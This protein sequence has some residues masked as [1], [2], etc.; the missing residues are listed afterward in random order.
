MQ[1]LQLMA[2]FLLCLC[3]CL[4]IRA[5]Q[6]EFAETF[7]E[8]IVGHMS[9]HFVAFR[10]QEQERS[11][12]ADELS[13]AILGRLDKNTAMDIKE[14]ITSAVEACTTILLQHIPLSSSFRPEQSAA[15]LD[16]VASFR[17]NLTNDGLKLH[18]RLR[19]AFLSG[20]R[21]PTPASHLLGNTCP[22]YEFVRKDLGVPMHGLANLYKW[23]GE[24]GGAV[25]GR[26]TGQNVSAIYKAIR[27][28]H[29]GVVMCKMFSGYDG[30]RTVE[31]KAR[32]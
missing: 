17:K 30:K 25:E 22:L 10:M 18:E 24:G 21:G 11:R 27:R 15:L 5:M 20:K 9:Q 31:E 28:G 29:I 16:A 2:S 6:K 13:D 12:I 4:D 23:E 26:T 1:H 7:K 14:R 3:Q 19:E 32:L 8:S